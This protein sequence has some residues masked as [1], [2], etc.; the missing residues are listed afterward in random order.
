MENKKIVSIRE[1]KADNELMTTMQ[2]FLEDAATEGSKARAL[3]MELMRIIKVHGRADSVGAIL[4]TILCMAKHLAH[5][6][7]MDENSVIASLCG[8]MLKLET[9]IDIDKTFSPN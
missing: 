2:E 8:V 4:L 5:D 1:I 7:K 6:L 9:D 3:T